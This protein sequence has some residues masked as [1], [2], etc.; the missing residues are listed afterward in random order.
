MSIFGIFLVCVFPHSDWIWRDTPCISVFSPNAGKHGPENSE[1]RHFLCSVS[2][3]RKWKID[4]FN[5]DT[6]ASKVATISDEHADGSIGNVT[7]SNSV[8]VFLGIGLAWSV[9]AIYHR[10]KGDDFRVEAGALGFSVLI[11]CIEALVCITIL[12]YRRFNKNINAELG[13]PSRSRKITS[14]AFV[15]LWIMYLLISALQSYC[16]ISA[17]FWIL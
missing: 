2:V 9:A 10:I 14:F 16:H 8:N 5:L 7:G 4:F 13:G 6:F 15:M 12:M 17:S 11:F 3:M 1:Y